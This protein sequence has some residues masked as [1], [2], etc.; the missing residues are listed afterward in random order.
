MPTPPLW[1]LSQLRLTASSIHMTRDLCQKVGPV[2][3]RGLSRRE[4]LHLYPYKLQCFLSVPQRY[5]G[6]IA[7]LGLTLS[8][9]EDV[10]GQVC[11]LIWQTSSSL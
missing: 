2:A 8:Y 4:D 6:D 11:G 10:M 1:S 7:D 9:D 3:V 5:D